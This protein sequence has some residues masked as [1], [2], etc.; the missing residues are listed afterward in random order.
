MPEK[1]TI[2]A[3]ANPRARCLPRSTSSCRCAAVQ[4]I[5]LVQTLSQLCGPERA[6]VALIGPGGDP[7]PGRRLPMMMYRILVM[8]AN[9]LGGAQQQV[10][11]AITEGLPLPPADLPGDLHHRLQLPGGASYYTRTSSLSRALVGRRR[12]V[13]FP[14]PQTHSRDKCPRARDKCPQ[15][16]EEIT[17]VVEILESA[18]SLPPF[19]LCVDV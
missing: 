2:D 1:K 13:L 3:K 9:H 12:L 6:P 11:R 17:Q 4:V 8:F 5:K 16:E 10:G 7:V 15:A 14:V 19:L 18:H